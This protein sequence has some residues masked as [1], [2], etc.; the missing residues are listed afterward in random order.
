[1][2]TINWGILG[3]GKIAHRFA[4]GLQVVDNAKLVGVGSRS[5]VSAAAFGDRFSVA[6]RHSSYEALVGD[7]SIDV[8]YVATPHS[9]HRDHTLL[10][11]NASKHV[12]CEKPFA[13]NSK[14]TV[15]MVTCALE[16]E[17]F[18]MEAMWIYFLPVICKLQEIISE[19]VIGEVRSLSATCGFAAKRDPKSRLF[20]PLLGGGA[21][22]DMG[23]Y[24]VSLATLLFGT[25]I[26]IEARAQLGDTGI[27][28]L[29]WM[30]MNFTGGIEADLSCTI[31]DDSANE[32]IITGTK[33]HVTIS[34][35]WWN[36]PKLILS[37]E[38]KQDEV[39]E[40][41]YIGNGLNYQA[42]HVGECLS[43]RR[44]ESDVMSHERTRSNMQV[45]DQIREQIG[46]RY[47]VEKG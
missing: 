3:T 15:E 26:E 9:M 27:D 4:E 40:P 23:I 31:T 45:L 6:N 25:P 14:E 8:I 43:D 32:A 11:L 41:R 36:G 39:I 19:G 16:N 12:L 46:L 35:R 21:L 38:G 2:K 33:G 30:R 20:D 47:P 13:I 28:E 44:L 37:L 5:K 10:S 22:L 24:P 34:S 7:P 42:A 1:M 29:T 18:L 17:R